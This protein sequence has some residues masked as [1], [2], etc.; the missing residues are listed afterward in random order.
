MRYFSECIL[1]NESPELNAEE[2]FAD[3]PVLEGFV[4]DQEIDQLS[5][6]GGVLSPSLTSSSVTCWPDLV[7]MRRFDCAG[8]LTTGL[9]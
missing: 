1:N 8:S 3:V 9:T 5:W 4:F 6:V 2:G 7:A